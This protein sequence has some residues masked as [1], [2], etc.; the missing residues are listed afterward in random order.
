MHTPFVSRHGVHIQRASPPKMTCLSSLPSSLNFYK[1]EPPPPPGGQVRAQACRG[2]PCLVKAKTSSPSSLADVTGN[3]PVYLPALSPVPASSCTLSR[4]K[5]EQA[6]LRPCAVSG[7]GAQAPP[8]AWLEQ[9]A[10]PARCSGCPTRTPAASTSRLLALLV[11]GNA[12]FAARTRGWPRLPAWDS[13]SDLHARPSPA[14]YP[15]RCVASESRPPRRP[16]PHRTTLLVSGSNPS[17][18][19][20]VRPH[21]LCPWHSLESHPSPPERVPVSPFTGSTTEGM[22]TVPHAALC[23]PPAPA[24]LFPAFISHHECNSLKKSQSG[25]H[26]AA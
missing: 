17:V 9:D 19:V 14:T 3:K 16:W 10:S 1:V 22:P 25:H 2:V 5:H 7:F 23:L 15:G 6:A 12:S 18:T 26:Q 8:G 4:S 11:L 21:T 24:Q 20:T 13:V